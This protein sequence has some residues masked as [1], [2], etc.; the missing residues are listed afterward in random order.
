MLLPSFISVLSFISDLAEPVL[1]GLCKLPVITLHR[2]KDSKSRWLISNFI[3]KL[4]K[5]HHKLAVKY[6]SA[7]IVEISQTFKDIVA[8]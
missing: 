5:Y 3:R 8:S 1:K 2:Y 7:N 4:L 6:L